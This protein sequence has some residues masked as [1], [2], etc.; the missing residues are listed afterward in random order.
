[1]SFYIIKFM[2]NRL[3]LFCLPRLFYPKTTSAVF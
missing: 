1:M 2:V 3:H